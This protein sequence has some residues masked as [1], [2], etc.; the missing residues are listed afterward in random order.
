M[1]KHAFGCN[2][3]RQDPAPPNRTQT[4]IHPTRKPLQAT[5]PNPPTGGR[6]HNFRRT[7]I[8][9]LHKGDP[10]HSKLNKMNKKRSIQQIKKPSKNTPEQTNVEGISSLPGKKK[11][12]QSNDSKD[13]PKS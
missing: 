4:Q 7:M 5:D 13:D 12:I 9:S 6:L 11:K 10:K 1:P 3:E 2:T 8:F